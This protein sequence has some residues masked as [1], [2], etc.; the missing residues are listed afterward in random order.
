MSAVR[1]NV[2]LKAMVVDPEVVGSDKEAIRELRA[3]IA[4]GDQRLSLVEATFEELVPVLNASVGLE[5]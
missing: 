5:A 3:L 1:S 4:A 2:N